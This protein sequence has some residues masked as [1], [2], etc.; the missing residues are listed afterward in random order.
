MHRCTALIMQCYG[1]AE[2]R[3][4]NVIE[5]QCNEMYAVALTSLE[6]SGLLD[7]VLA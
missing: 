7:L 6:L 3:N 1:V 2:R 5:M 4:I